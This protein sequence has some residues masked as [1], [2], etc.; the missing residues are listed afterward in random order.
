MPKED[1]VWYFFN[2]P[3]SKYAN[4]KRINRTTNS[5]FWKCT[6][7]DRVIWDKQGKKIGFK[8]N[9]VFHKGRVPNGIR[10]NW[11][12][13]EYHSDNAFLYPV[14]FVSF[15]FSSL[16]FLFNLDYYYYYFG[17]LAY[18][19]WNPLNFYSVCGVLVV[20]VS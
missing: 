2:A 13:H 1:R 10:T 9:L 18:D 16:S 15:S 12:I 11:V 3:V 14:F 19:R 20:A 5:G 6:G 7:K 17:V 4:S 8:K